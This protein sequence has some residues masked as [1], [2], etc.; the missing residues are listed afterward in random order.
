MAYIYSSHSKNVKIPG[1]K[2][3]YQLKV[4]WLQLFARYPFVPKAKQM[5]GR[6]RGLQAKM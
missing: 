3:Y 4:V 2:F 5:F 6:A 1:R